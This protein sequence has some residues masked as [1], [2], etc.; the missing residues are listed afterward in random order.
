MRPRS[1]FMRTSLIRLIALLLTFSLVQDPGLGQ[2]R[3]QSSELRKIS[4]SCALSS[5]LFV[6][7][8]VVPAVLQFH[9]QPLAQGLTVAITA[10]AGILLSGLILHS[11][12]AMDRAGDFSRAKLLDM[13][14]LPDFYGMVVLGLF[15]VLLLGLS[16]FLTKDRLLKLKKEIPKKSLA[17][18]EWL[19][20]LISSPFEKVYPVRAPYDPDRPAYNPGIAYEM[21]ELGI[22]DAIQQARHA[23]R[24]MTWDLRYPSRHP[25][26]RGENFGWGDV[27]QKGQ[28]LLLRL[29]QYDD[30][31]RQHP[32]VIT[33]GNDPTFERGEILMYVNRGRIYLDARLL[34]FVL[35]HPEHEEVFKILLDNARFSHSVRNLAYRTGDIRDDSGH[36][37]QRTSDQLAIQ[38]FFAAYRLHQLIAT[39][40]HL[41]VYEMGERLVDIRKAN[42]GKGPWP[43]FTSPGGAELDWPGLEEDGDLVWPEAFEEQTGRAGLHGPPVL[44]V[45]F[46]L[47]LTAYR[48]GGTGEFAKALLLSVEP[49]QAQTKAALRAAHRP[50][51]V[52]AAV[53]SG[54]KSTMDRAAARVLNDSP[55]PRV[56]T[57]WQE[58]DL[59]WRTLAAENPLLE[60]AQIHN[61]NRLIVNFYALLWDLGGPLSPGSTHPYQ[62]HLNRLLD[63][64]FG[65]NG[66]AKFVPPNLQSSSVEDE[67]NKNEIIGVVGAD[68]TL[69]Y[70]TPHRGFF[71]S[72]DGKRLD[73]ESPGG[74]M[75][76]LLAPFT[77]F[78]TASDVGAVKGEAPR[79]I[80]GTVNA[81]VAE[82]GRHY[83]A[84]LF[85]R[86]LGDPEGI[87]ERVDDADRIL[88]AFPNGPE[89]IT[90]AVGADLAWPLALGGRAVV[91]VEDNL[92][93]LRGLQDYY[94]RHE[95]DLQHG[96]V[97]FVPGRLD[98]PAVRRF[99]N[100]FKSF[101]NIVSP[102]HMM[103]AAEVARW[104]SPLAGLLYLGPESDADRA[105]FRRGLA[106]EGFRVNFQHPVLTP[107]S[108]GKPE[109]LL[110][111]VTG[112]HRPP[113]ISLVLSLPQTAINRF[114]G[115]HGVKTAVSLFLANLGSLGYWGWQIVSHHAASGSLHVLKTGLGFDISPSLQNIVIMTAAFAAIYL[116]S[117]AWPEW[118]AWATGYGGGNGEGERSHL[119]EVE[120]NRL[121]L[122]ENV[123]FTSGGGRH[124][125][126]GR[127]KMPGIP[128]QERIREQAKQLVDLYTHSMTETQGRIVELLNREGLWAVLGMIKPED[129]EGSIPESQPELRHQVWNAVI[130]RSFQKDAKIR[131]Y[132]HNRL[133]NLD[134]KSETPQFQG[135]EELPREWNDI[136]KL[137]HIMVKGHLPQ[138]GNLKVG[139][140]WGLFKEYGDSLYELE[141]KDGFPI[142]MWIGRQHHLAVEFYPIE[143]V[144]PKTCARIQTGA[145]T[146]KIVYDVFS[147]FNNTVV[148]AQLD[149]LSNLRIG[150]GPSEING[151]RPKKEKR[152]FWAQLTDRLYAYEHVEFLVM[153]GLICEMRLLD[154]DEIRR[155]TL[156]W[157]K[158]MR[159]FTTSFLGHLS[160]DQLLRLGDDYELFTYEP[161]LFAPSQSMSP[162]MRLPSLP[163]A[164]HVKT[165]AAPT[166]TVPQMVMPTTPPGH[167]GWMVRLKKDSALIDPQGQ[168]L[169]NVYAILTPEGIELEAGM[170]VYLGHSAIVIGSLSWTGTSN[171]P[172]L[173]GETGV[174]HGQPSGERVVLGGASV[175]ELTLMPTEP[176]RRN[177][178]KKPTPPEGFRKDV[179]LSLFSNPAYRRNLAGVESL[180]TGIFIGVPT[181]LL[182][183][184]LGLFG[185]Q[186]DIVAAIHNLGWSALAAGFYRWI[187]PLAHGYRDE[188][189]WR[190]FIRNGQYA[191]TR[192]AVRQLEKVFYATLITGGILSAL[193]HWS[194]WIP[195]AI[196]AVLVMFAHYVNDWTYQWAHM[197]QSTLEPPLT[198]EGLNWF[199]HRF[200]QFFRS[201]LGLVEL[202]LQLPLRRYHGRAWE[203]RIRLA[204]RQLREL[205]WFE[206]GR[207]L[208]DR[209]IEAIRKVE[210]QLGRR[211]LRP[212][213][214]EFWHKCR[215]T[216]VAVTDF[217]EAMADPVS[218][219]PIVN[220][221]ERKGEKDT[222]EFE[223]T[224]PSALGT[225]TATLKFRMNSWAPLLD[226][227]FKWKMQLLDDA[228]RVLDVIR[229]GADRAASAK[230]C[231]AALLHIDIGPDTETYVKPWFHNKSLT[232]GFSLSRSRRGVRANFLDFLHTF[233][234]YLEG[235]SVH[236]PLPRAIDQSA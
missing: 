97:T 223:V 8:A 2:M 90:L 131:W 203:E 227:H 132:V 100:T 211:N 62:E 32:F 104:K 181:V 208:T 115:R 219:R 165:E 17:F 142:R 235:L 96:S 4:E 54:I 21:T 217:L 77:A 232:E 13:S 103:T 15:Y 28:A 234:A 87:R 133:M 162:T 63:H 38:Q 3:T 194:P 122:E 48:D 64:L 31:V 30:E 56:K 14:N 49:G 216:L 207:P 53:W 85:A 27:L 59:V 176:I 189:G 186:L 200:R 72:D 192:S 154:S 213:D 68:Q 23:G 166:A 167:Q 108:R 35:E 205:V 174:S 124:K 39:A 183:R 231:L 229:L 110:L 160:E 78:P 199:Y 42:G 126:T 135:M 10:A 57:Q 139:R 230:H 177:G 214:E 58:A 41:D 164:T 129:A 201:D 193:M 102:G 197:D 80:N 61:A 134:A 81:T 153:N 19:W 156:V 119:H 148:T 198:P 5:G 137:G 173:V 20:D 169:V 225:V 33:F 55:D 11:H 26:K 215:Q 51:F 150:G 155:Y 172:H 114:V 74:D 182:M 123:D 218:M 228:W 152:K 82:E 113:W 202:S 236:S 117:W 136:A 60:S 187:F 112:G 233:K 196:A 52:P 161:S 92:N 120:W 88:G 141:M 206:S 105:E 89:D 34:Q 128:H 94:H 157:H 7:Q 143:S 138:T 221:L 168:E 12:A 179:E 71:L 22:R 18:K 130:H 151:E 93:K 204:V 158:P 16:R 1:T 224:F 185:G 65:P 95:A 70:P 29:T 9:H 43:L 127:P 36:R 195:L 75:Y 46:K 226:V 209:F 111:A 118:L 210:T 83:V 106:R 84:E 67:H 45:H 86:D 144:D 76:W 24:T 69:Y 25:G 184:H 212:E 180:I 66:L 175:G 99:L 190:H 170:T 171:G 220:K 222:E 125:P 145:H 107:N 91:V 163:V 188:H 146:G 149:S 40:H 121:M 147:Q 44:R 101:T 140:F 116:F 37:Y 47:E 73:I 109:G 98:D 159:K 178:A 79:R 6:E 50:V 191:E